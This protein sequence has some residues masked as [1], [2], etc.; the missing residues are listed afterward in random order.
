MRLRE[1]AVSSVGQLVLE[2]V[3]AASDI[4]LSSSTW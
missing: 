2:G 4:M 3:A 1:I